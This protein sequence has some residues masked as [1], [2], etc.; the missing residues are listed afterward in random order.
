MT[1]SKLRERLARLGPIRAVDRVSS[2]SPATLVLRARA[3][4]LLTIDATLA[5]ARR[6]M[7]LLRAKRAVEAAMIGEGVAELPTVESLPALAG[8]LR[9]AGFDVTAIGTEAID[10]KALR[11]GLGMSQEQFAR[12]YGLELDAVQNWE[13]QRR[14]IEGTALRYLR[15]I[16]ADPVGAARAQEVEVI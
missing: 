1:Q 10:V 7:T 8:E 12:R 11:E 5:L 15:T 3:G 2:G 4:K 16:Q 9:E 6:G 13:Q 14:P